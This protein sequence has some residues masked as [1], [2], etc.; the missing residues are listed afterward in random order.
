MRLYG[1]LVRVVH[2][3]NQAGARELRTLG[4]TPAQYQLLVLV[5]A[6]PE[7]SQRQIAERLGV[8]TGNVSML[9]TRLE[10]AGLV[11]RIPDGAAY[12]LR[13]T[14]AGRDALDRI[15]PLHAEFLVHCFSRLDDDQL[16]TLERLVGLLDPAS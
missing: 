11:V 2:E 13:L 7:S 6:S 4:F 16:A 3:I 10:Q 1:D 12:G 14:H 9:V 15:R 8:T 5:D